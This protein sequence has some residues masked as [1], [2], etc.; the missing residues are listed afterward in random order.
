M[1]IFK[2]IGDDGSVVLQVLGL[3]I[4]DLRSRLKT[5]TIS[6]KKAMVYGYLRHEGGYSYQEIGD[7]CYKDHSTIVESVKKNTKLY[8]IHRETILK[9]TQEFCK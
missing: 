9:K 6:S 8:K 4:G 5:R 2:C 1:D 3:D 7:Y